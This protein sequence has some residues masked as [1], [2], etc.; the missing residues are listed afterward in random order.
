[1]IGTTNFGKNISIKRGAAIMAY[2]N[3]IKPC[4]IDAKKLL[5]FLKQYLN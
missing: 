3:P 2:P 1:M 4:K 5:K